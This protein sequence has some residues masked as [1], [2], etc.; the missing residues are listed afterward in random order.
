M[1]WIASEDSMA[2]A[3]GTAASWHGEEKVVDADSTLA[4]WRAASGLNFTVAKSQSY[5]NFGGEF[6]PVDGRHHLVRDNGVVLGQCSDVYRVVQPETIADFFNDF[7]L[8]D[9]RFTMDTMGAVKGG[10]IVWALAKFADAPTILDAKHD[11]HCLLATSYDGTMATRAGAVAT[12]VVCRNT[13]QAAAYEQ[14]TIS[15][16]HSAEFTKIKQADAVAQMAAVAA[17][18]DG[19]KALAESLHK[20][21][22]GY[23]STVEFFKALNGIDRSAKPEDVSTRSRNIIDTMLV[24]LAKTRNEPGTSDLTA[25]TALNTVTRFVDHS[26]S[27]K[28]TVAGE[29]AGEAALFATQF[30]TGAAMKA[31]AV[32]MLLAA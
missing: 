13:L 30:G 21:K 4:E 25:W 2:R 7:I 8:S 32:D 19:Y 15:I 20:I 27:T 14:A 11:L 10:R 31:R 22:L 6:T 28:R 3:A 24:D 12:R 9:S 23:D 29:T 17:Q 5:I 16:R 26:R 18:F 1:A